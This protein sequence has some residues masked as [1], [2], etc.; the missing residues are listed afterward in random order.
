MIQTVIPPAVERYG[1]IIFQDRP[2]HNGDLFSRRH[3][4]MSQPNRAKIFAPFA[5]LVGFDERVHRKEIAYVPRHLLDA[6]EEWE[7]NQT[8]YKIHCLTVNSRLARINKVS[9]SVEYFVLCTDEENDAYQIKGQYNA[10]TGTVLKVD[11]HEQRINL[12]CDGAVH[13]ILFSDIYRIT[14]A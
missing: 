4:R 14:M 3:P 5:A 8:L 6:D 11:T 1:D 13:A 9:V 12:C 10:I 7:L 2:G